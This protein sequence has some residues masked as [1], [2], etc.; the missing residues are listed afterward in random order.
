[1]QGGLG[2]SWH[3]VA[4]EFDL[5]NAGLV[6]WKDPATSRGSGWGGN[7]PTEWEESWA[8]LERHASW[9]GLSWLRVEMS[10]RMYEPGRGRFDWTSDEM[11]A[12]DR[13]LAWCDRSGADVL[14]QQM[15]S[16]VEWNR[17]PGVAA[18]QSGPRDVGAYAEGL[19]TAVEHLR[20]DRGHGSIRWLDLAN[21]PNIGGGWWLGPDHQ[22]LP[23]GPALAAVRAALD[24]RGIDLPLS[25]PG[26]NRLHDPQ[27]DLF[28]WENDPSI[29]A[30]DCHN[31]SGARALDQMEKWVGRAR[32]RDIP[33]FVS[34]MGDFK[35]GWKGR[36]AG[37]ASFEAALSLAAQVLGGIELGVDGFSRWSYTNRGDLDGQWQ[38]VRTWDPE[39]RRYLRRVAPEPVPYFAFAVLARYWA[40][41]S[42]AL[43]TLRHGAE[44]VSAAALESPRGELTLLV[45]NPLESEVG[46]ELV[47]ESVERATR[48]QRYQVTEQGLEA[49]GA[50]QRLD[51]EPWCPLVPGR[52]DAT[53]RLPPRS[54]TA[55]STYSVLHE[56]AGVA[57]E[58]TDVH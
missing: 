13:I 37:P 35:L 55:Y 1:M 33:F 2:A 50:A 29:G 32:R 5:S 27:A 49:A 41:R 25:A 56:A 31:Y 14:L 48:L 39:A 23:L 57:S 26:W 53:D 54:L 51:P 45:A 9:L 18:L 44:E 15:W 4:R 7:P 52:N 3:A 16:F 28:D 38:L 21:E 43:A 19:A 22:P 8:E 34:E 6:G 58:T 42:T 36:S 11:R 40:N 12:L 46:V 30:F 17:F 24:R 10:Q 20:R 47:L